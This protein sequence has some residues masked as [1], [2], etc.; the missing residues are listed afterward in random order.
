MATSKSRQ[1]GKEET[2]AGTGLLRW[3][4][5]LL[6]GAGGHLERA[7]MTDGT[8]VPFDAPVRGRSS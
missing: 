8:P 5:N 4:A 6:H 2:L 3:E 7:R 1:L